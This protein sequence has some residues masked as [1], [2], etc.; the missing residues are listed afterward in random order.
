MTRLSRRVWWAVL[1]AA[2]TGLLLSLV[3][4]VRAPAGAPDVR[5]VRGAASAPPPPAP[6]SRG[7][8]DPETSLRRDGRSVDGRRALAVRC[9]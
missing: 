3:V 9:P 2:A 1:G 8:G 4:A 5:E 6:G 7:A